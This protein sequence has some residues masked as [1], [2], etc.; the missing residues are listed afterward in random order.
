MSFNI[1]CIDEGVYVSPQLTA[2]HMK[3]LANAGIRSII[4]NRPDMEGGALQPG[5]RELEAAALAAGLQ[6]EHLPVHPA[7][8]SEADALRMAQLVASLPKPVLA[9]CRSGRRSTALYGFGRRLVSG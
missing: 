8:H 1:E 2:D 4:N 9:F 5:S 3:P 6:Y 7:G